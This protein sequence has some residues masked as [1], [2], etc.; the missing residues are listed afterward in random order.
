[1]RADTDGDHC[2]HSALEENGDDERRGAAEAQQLGVGEYEVV[3]ILQL[4]H[5]VEQHYGGDEDSQKEYCPIAL[6]RFR[7]LCLIMFHN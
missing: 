4:A 1:M 2:R 6:L 3:V 7:G 5:D